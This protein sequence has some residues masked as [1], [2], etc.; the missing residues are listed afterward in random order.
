[1]CLSVF[2]IGSFYEQSLSHVPTLKNQN[3][4]M[5]MCGLKR[6]ENLKRAHAGPSSLGCLYPR[7]GQFYVCLGRRRA[8]RMAS[9][10]FEVAIQSA[11]QEKFSYTM[12]VLGLLGG[13]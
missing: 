3:H 12:V 6:R 8:R 13:G 2:Y 5:T 9:A 4:I 11:F 1:M 7:H 10:R